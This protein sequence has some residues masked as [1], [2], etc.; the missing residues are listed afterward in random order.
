MLAGS[1]SKDARA[2]GNKFL[3]G[4]HLL[5]MTSLSRQLYL[6]EPHND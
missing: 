1:A 4:F 6:C 2:P 3:I 5:G